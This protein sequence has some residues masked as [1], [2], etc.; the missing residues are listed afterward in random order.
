MTNDERFFL[1]FQDAMNY[2]G[3]DESHPYTQ[4]KGRDESRPYKFSIFIFQFP[5]RGISQSQASEEQQ[6]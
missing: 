6:S 3:R 5:Q 2:I 4:K 1:Q